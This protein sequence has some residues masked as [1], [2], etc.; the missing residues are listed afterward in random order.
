[1]EELGPKGQSVVGVLGEGAAS[2]SP[3]ARG[4]A[5]AKGTD[6]VHR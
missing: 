3:P 5:T 4:Y 6:I 2:S 1:M